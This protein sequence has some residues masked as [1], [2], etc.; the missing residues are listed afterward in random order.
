VFKNNGATRLTTSRVWEYVV[1]LHSIANVTT[2]TPSSHRYAYDALNRRVGAT[3][4]DGSRWAYDYNDRNELVSARRLWADQSPVSGQ[5]F[6]FAFDNI[7]N[8][9]TNWS[10]GDVNGLNLRSSAFTVNS[11]NQYSSITVPGYRPVTGVAH[12]TATVTVAGQSTDRKGEYY[13]R[14]LSIANGSGP[15]WTTVTVSSTTNVTGN[16]LVPPATRSLTYDDDGNLTADARWTGPSHSLIATRCR[17]CYAAE[18]RTPERSVHVKAAPGLA[19]TESHLR[20]D[21]HLAQREPVGIALGRCLVAQRNPR[22]EGAAGMGGNSPRTGFVS[23]ARL[24]EDPLHHASA[25]FLFTAVREGLD[26]V[27]CADMSHRIPNIVHFVFGL[28]GPRQILHYFHYL[29]VQSAIL[30]NR[31]EAVYFH[32]EH[33]PAGLWWQRTRSLIIPVQRTAPTHVGKKQLDHYAHRADVLRLE[34][35]L[36]LGGVY[37]DLDTLCLRP[38]HDLLDRRFVIGEEPQYDN[39][40]AGLCNA[41]MFS[42]PGSA[43]ARRWLDKYPAHFTPGEWANTGCILPRHLANEPGMRN[44]VTI[45]PTWRFHDPTGPGLFLPGEL[46]ARLMVAHYWG[47][48]PL[49]EKMLI[50]SSPD[51]VRD[52]PELIFSKMVRT[53]FGERLPGEE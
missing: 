25:Y 21:L 13:H 43:F 11:L 26:S 12:A 41:V 36:K 6:Q 16:L 9:K 1:R 39:P 30:V 51:V 53:V 45:E 20:A 3:L 27:A 49:S 8:L 17:C 40:V 15:V 23:S 28:K 48:A 10:G 22:R 19:D 38:W 2:N 32:F 14:E 52:E 4:V 33:E 5:Q 35:L 31:P 29:A 42:I 7:G 50:G 24:L 34:I 46:P 47:H 37:L 18:R 44:E